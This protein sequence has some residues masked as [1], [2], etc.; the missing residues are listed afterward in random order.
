MK[1]EEWFDSGYGLEVP[2][3]SLVPDLVVEPIG[4][5]ISASCAPD[6]SKASPVDPYGQTRMPAEI[7]QASLMLDNRASFLNRL[8]IKGS[9]A[10]FAVKLWTI[11][12]DE[13]TTSFLAI[14]SGCNKQNYINYPNFWV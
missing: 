11:W 5:S 2:L 10:D 1:C 9:F 13:Q 12:G 6:L 3:I 4:G 8:L 14:I 7:Q